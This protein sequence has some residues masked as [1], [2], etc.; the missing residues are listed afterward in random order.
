[1]RIEGEGI[2]GSELRWDVWKRKAARTKTMICQLV[3]GKMG[4]PEAKVAR[5]L[6]ITISSFNR[7]A[8]SE[9][10]ADFKKYLKML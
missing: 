4:Y 6:G 10:A 2:E 8:V 3:Q 5:Y 9:E 7:L 1:L